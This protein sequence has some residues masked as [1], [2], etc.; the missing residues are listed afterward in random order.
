MLMTVNCCF[1]KTTVHRKYLF[2][3]LFDIWPCCH[4]D[5]MPGSTI[6]EKGQSMEKLARIVYHFVNMV[7]GF[8]STLRMWILDGWA[9]SINKTLHALSDN[10]SWNYLLMLHPLL[11]MKPCALY[12]KQKK[13]KK[14]FWC[15]NIK[16]SNKAFRRRC[17]SKQWQ[18]LW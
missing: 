10:S 1:T 5:C 3:S 14:L 13:K 18:V 4:W 6:E 12:L 17:A 16:K 2:I 8:S 7:N 15:E 9:S 11:H